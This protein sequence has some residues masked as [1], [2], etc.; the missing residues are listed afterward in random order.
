MDK[1]VEDSLNLSIYIGCPEFICESYFN[2]AILCGKNNDFDKLDT[3]IDLSVYFLNQLEFNRN[4]DRF[5]SIGF[6]FYKLGNIYEAIKN[7]KKV[8][9]KKRC[10]IHTSF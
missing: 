8:I 6:V 1:I 10:D 2:K 9:L 5:L 3:Y 4:S 7:F